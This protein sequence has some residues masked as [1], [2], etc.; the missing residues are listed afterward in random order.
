MSTMTKSKPTK[1]P[2]RTRRLPAIVGERR[3]VIRGVD[4]EIYDKLSDAVVEGQHVRMAYDG[5]D[6]EIMTT[7]NVHEYFK[8]FLGQ[9]VSEV[10]TVLA[11]PRL[12]A[13]ATTWKRPKLARI[14]GRSVLLLPPREACGC[15][16]SRE[17]TVKEHRRLSQPRPWGRDRYFAT[18]S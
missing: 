12:P 8:D 16:R 5:K 18:R 11:I 13:G 7:G 1:S 6:L 4:W 3:I 14:R 15:R 9:F 2:V 10:A 17:A